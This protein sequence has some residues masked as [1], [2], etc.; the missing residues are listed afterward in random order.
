MITMRWKEDYSFGLTMERELPNAVDGVLG[1]SAA[2][3]VEDIKSNWS[4]FAPPHSAP[5]KPPA[6]YEGELDEETKVYDQGRSAGGQ[7]ASGGGQFRVVRIGSDHAQAMET[8]TE[9]HEARPFVLPAV[10]R[11]QAVF[12][13]QM[14]EIFARVRRR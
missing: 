8:G 14:R 7:F 1:D 9:H 5:G 11:L 2:W 12:P 3:L 4:G 13:Q 10:E 6:I